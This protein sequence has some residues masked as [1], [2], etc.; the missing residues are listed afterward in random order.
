MLLRGLLILGQSTRF[1]YAVL[2]QIAKRNRPFELK[3]LV[4]KRNR[5]INEDFI[6]E[7]KK[8]SKQKKIN[9]NL[10]DII[11]GLNILRYF[12]ERDFSRFGVEIIFY[13]EIT[14][15]DNAHDLAFDLNIRHPIT[16]QQINVPIVITG[17]I[18]RNW[19]EIWEEENE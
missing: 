14:N 6:S 3:F 18:I 17:D 16:G 15:I 7:I 5:P 9:T 13:E 10:C 8:L 19:F 1:Q 2:I 11:V 12:E 4:L